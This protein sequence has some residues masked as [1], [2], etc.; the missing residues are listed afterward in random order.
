M[1]LFY[2]FIFY[3]SALRILWYDSKPAFHPLPT[4]SCR[5]GNDEAQKKPRDSQVESPLE[6]PPPPPCLQC[7]VAS[8]PLLTHFRYFSHL[9]SLETKTQHN[10]C[11]CLFCFWC[12]VQGRWIFSSVGG[13]ASRLTGAHSLLLC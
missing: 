6:L 12:W 9:F 2:L 5:E 4:T 3:S 1:Y 11:F 7:A 13:S 10:N 8:P